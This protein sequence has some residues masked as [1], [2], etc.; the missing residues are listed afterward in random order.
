MKTAIF[1]ALMM[2]SVFASAKDNV[3]NVPAPKAQQY[4]YSTHLDI[5]KVISMSTA[6]VSNDESGLAEAHMV[7]VDHQGV[8]HNVEYTV[9][10]YSDK[11]S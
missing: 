9:D 1:A 3:T 4:T 8:T 7:Y 2:A 6:E 10:A 11:N 5:A